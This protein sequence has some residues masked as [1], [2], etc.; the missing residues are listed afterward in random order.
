MI[1]KHTSDVPT[2]PID[3]PGFSKMQ[4]RFLLV[5][6]DGC[7]RYAMR[8]MEIAPGGCTSYHSHREEHEMYFLEG[9]GVLKTENSP[10]CNVRAGDA[11]LLM[12]CEMH[13]IRNTGKGLLKMIYTVPLFPGKNG[14]ETTS[15]D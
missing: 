6:D 8:L 11:L 3:K 9:E 13:Q 7:P 2:V 4:A 10:E 14:K 15:C 12:P 5:A 1:L